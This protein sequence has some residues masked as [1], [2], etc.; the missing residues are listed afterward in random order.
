MRWGVLVVEWT[1]VA[2]RNGSQHQGCAGATSMLPVQSCACLAQ[3]SPAHASRILYHI[4]LN[5]GLRLSPRLVTERKTQVGCGPGR[6]DRVRQGALKYRLH[7]YYSGAGIAVFRVLTVCP[8]R[9]CC[10]Q[11]VRTIVQSVFNSSVVSMLAWCALCYIVLL[12]S[13]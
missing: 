6:L 11:H 12:R 1:G 4:L 5:G 2:G 13:V 3:V 7:V 9:D 8:Q 10:S